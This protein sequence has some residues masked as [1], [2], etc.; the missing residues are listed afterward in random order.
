MTQ[1]VMGFEPALAPPA[2][3]NPAAVAVPARREQGLSRGVPRWICLVLADA[4]AVAVS[5]VVVLTYLGETVAGSL[6]VV[7]VMVAFFLAALA[8][9]GSYGRY[10]EGLIVSR[11]L[12]R[13]G[14]LYGLPLG[15]VLASLA[16][17]A[18]V[19][20]EPGGP[21][22]EQAGLVAVLG[23]AAIPAARVLVLALVTPQRRGPR[24]LFLRP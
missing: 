22:V 18:A 8:A 9:S 5:T 17:Q 6:T 14:V 3:V 11:R 1:R 20:D 15:V 4:V 13:P 19:P 12:G 10:A 16:G 21:G 2:A 24:G 7:A 23:L